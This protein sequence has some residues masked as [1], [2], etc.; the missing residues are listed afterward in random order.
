MKSK[1]PTISSWVMRYTEPPPTPAATL[2]QSSGDND[3]C[4][5]LGSFSCNGVNCSEMGNIAPAATALHCLMNYSPVVHL[6]TLVTHQMIANSNPNLNPN[7]DPTIK[8]HPTI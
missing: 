8:Q 5:E 6:L 3:V 4:A 2:A 7:P 1:L